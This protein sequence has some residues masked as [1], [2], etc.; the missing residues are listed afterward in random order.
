MRRKTGGFTLVE[1]VIA[2]ALFSLVLGVALSL[3]GQGV[4]LFNRQ[5]AE[6]EAEE[7]ARI[8]LD[9]L[10]R[11]LRTAVAVEEIGSNYV[12]L[13]LSD[14]TRVR[15]YH[16]SNRRQLMREVSRGV[17]PV[18]SF[19]T[20]LSFASDPPNPAGKRGVL[21]KIVLEVTDTRGRSTTLNTAV[22]VR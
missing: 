19:I 20:G 2:V 14:G 4:T 10:V 22:F 17:N 11:E 12:K 6:V 15:Y 3:Y 9:R 1:V 13:V 7:N 21:V 8:A 18:A 5:E 16:D